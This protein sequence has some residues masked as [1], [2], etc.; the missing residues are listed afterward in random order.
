MSIAGAVSCQKSLCGNMEMHVEIVDFDAV[1]EKFDYIN[2]GTY[3]KVYK[4]RKKTKDGETAE[5]AVKIQE[6]SFVGGEDSSYVRTLNEANIWGCLD[7]KNIVKLYQCFH[8]GSE[9][10][11][12]MELILGENLFDEILKRAQYTER[13]ACLYMRQILSA[14]SYLHANG[15]VHR[16]VKPDNIMLCHGGGR[17][18]TTSVVKLADFGLARRLPNGERRMNCTPSGAPLYLAPETIMEVALSFPVDIWSCGVILYI[19][20]YGSPPF[21]SEDTNRLLLDIVG[22]EVDYSC[23]D[24]DTV[25]FLGKDLI[26]EMLVKDQNLRITASDALEH[27]WMLQGAKLSREHRRSTL[28]QLSLFRK[29]NSVFDVQQCLKLD[30][31][32]LDNK[33]RNGTNDSTGNEDNQ[34]E[35]EVS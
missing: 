29:C 18:A 12:V 7:H 26:Q 25:S 33:I 11:F 31:T 17:S 14:L 3:G 1:Y 15:I 32:S 24:G 2:G 8:Q 35:E 34:C 13:D 21:W 16:D 23:N 6:V 10:Y 22:A 9:F 5:Y 4:C 28:E 20:L 27:P 30:R 19:M